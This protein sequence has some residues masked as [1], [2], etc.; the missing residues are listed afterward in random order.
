MCHLLLPRFDH[1][2]NIKL[3]RDQVTAVRLLCIYVQIGVKLSVPL[4]YQKKC[5]Y[6]KNSPPMNGPARGR[7]WKRTDSKDINREFIFRNAFSRTW[8]KKKKRGKKSGV[9]QSGLYERSGIFFPRIFIR[10]RMCAGNGWSRA[11]FFRVPRGKKHHHFYT[12]Y[13]LIPK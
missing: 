5:L 2:G 9:R 4:F 13:V 10:F 8:K 12:Y 11:S 1:A 7:R 3:F 6:Q